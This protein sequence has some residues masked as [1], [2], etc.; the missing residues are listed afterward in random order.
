MRGWGYGKARLG[1]FQIGSQLHVRAGLGL[2][3]GPTRA[4]GS[5]WSLVGG[6]QGGPSLQL[7]VCGRG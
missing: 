6:V 2:E 7:G 1:S 4:T 3:V 5:T